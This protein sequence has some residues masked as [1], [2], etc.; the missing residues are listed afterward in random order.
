MAGIKSITVRNLA[1]KS[2]KEMDETLIL[3]WDFGIENVLD[4]SDRVTGKHIKTAYRALGIPTR[5]EFSSQAFWRSMFKLSEDEFSLLL[6]EL[7]ISVTNGISALPKNS[8]KKLKSE[9]LKRNILQVKVFSPPPPRKKCPPES[10]YEWKQIGKKREMR[11]L[12]YEEILSIHERLVIDFAHHND[13]I[14]PPGVKD[15]NLLHSAIFR[16]LTSIGDDQ[17]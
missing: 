6:D 4:P 12:T 3:L 8:V 14:S 7:S 15:K 2:Y 11:M 5:R 17:F 9:A 1:R 16:P 10:S 13:P